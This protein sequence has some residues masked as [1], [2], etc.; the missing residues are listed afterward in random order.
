MTYRRV[1]AASQPRLIHSVPDEEYV[2][3]FRGMFYGVL[4]SVPCWVAIAWV[5][6]MF[7]NWLGR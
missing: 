6:Q 1:P 2:R 3:A 7:W 5:G 4:L